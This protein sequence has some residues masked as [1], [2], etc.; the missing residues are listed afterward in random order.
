MATISV[1]IIL[2][3]A[4]QETDNA[5]ARESFFTELDVEVTNCLIAND[6]PIIVGDMNA[7]VK[8]KDGQITHA[9]R[10]GKL[11]MEIVQND[12]L[13]ILNFHERCSGKWTH[14]IRTTGA[15]STLDYVITSNEVTKCVEKITI[16]EECL[17]CPFRI[18]K[19][20]SKSEPK[21]SDHNAI[22]TELKIEHERTVSRSQ[23]KWRITTEGL[24]EFQKLTTEG[25]DMDLTG[26]NIQE[27]YDALERKINILMEQCFRKVKGKKPNQL[28]THFMTKYKEITSFARRGKIQRKIAKTYIQEIKNLNT[29]AVAEAE[30]EKVKH[31]LT[32][33]T[34][35][36]KFSPNNFWELCKKSR[37]RGDTGTSVVNS[38][39]SELFGIDLISNAY[40][41]EF[42]YRLRKREIAPELRNYEM[43][44]EQICRLYLDEA[45]SNKEP[46]YTQEE[47]DAVCKGLKRGKACGRD[48]FPPD[49][50]IRGGDQLH[51][52]ILSLLNQIKSSDQTIHQW[53]LVL[54]ATIYKNKGSRKQLVNHRGIFLK[55]I[56]SKMF[57]KLNM[58]RIQGN[59]QKIDKFQAGNQPNR[60]P[61]DQT[62]LLRATVDHCKYIKKCLYIVLYDYKQCFD[63]LWLSDCLLS[64]WKLG[65]RSETLKN[66]RNLNETCNM[67][68]KTPVGITEQAKVTSIVQQ[69]SVSGGVLCSAS[70]AEVTKENLGRGCQIGTATVKAL[71]FVD[72]IASTNTEVP[73]TYQSH[74]NIV[75]FSKKKRIPLNIPKCVGLCV[76][77][78]H[79]D[80]IPRLKIDEQIIK[81]TNVAVYLGDHFNATGNNKDLEEDR[82]KKGRAC[83]ITATSLCSETTMEVYTIQT[84]MLLYKSLFLPVVLYNCQAWSNITKHELSLLNT[85]QL[86]FLK[87]IFHAPPSTSNPITFLETGSLPI[88]QE[89]NIRQLTFLHHV[90]TLSTS[91]PVNRV[92]K[93]QLKLCHENN[94]ASMQRMPL[95]I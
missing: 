30:K 20:K 8:N 88:E 87:R 61:A 53:T 47:Y 39:G 14:V 80:I 55:Q 34:I 78:K 40:L 56:L 68:I 32:K 12:Q 72:D 83:I 92:Y 5:D 19:Y 3:Y 49:I 52:L 25:M 31:I 50:F 36:D 66:L 71:T 29:E 1:R 82:V 38:G 62:F 63:S 74:N 46:P 60:S 27:K 91:D 6:L 2:G 37:H 15:A 17:L 7:K 11:L 43:R 90:L 42:V 13:E 23:K 93:E 18:E 33:L 64:L 28:T 22:I 41:E 9:S 59:I 70:T 51:T 21:Y 85:V 81:W 24:D 69:G 73:D 45:R 26:N 58:N 77:R 4:P 75:W 94:W 95:I 35:D 79:T 84:L 65:V 48:L 67:V 57:E 44:T 76:N 54:I 89:I 86:K 10:N 16:D